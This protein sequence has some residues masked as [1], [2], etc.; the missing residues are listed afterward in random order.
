MTTLPYPRLTYL[1]NFGH[2]L[3]AASYLYRPT[4]AEQI[5]EIF[6]FA[7]KNGLKVT[8]R[9]PAAPTTMPRSTA[10]ES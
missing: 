7:R 3:Q 2:S 1:E 8:L 5:G 4:T 6:Q 9:G 10:A